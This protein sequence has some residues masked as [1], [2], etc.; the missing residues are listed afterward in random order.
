MASTMIA[1]SRA[2]FGPEDEQA[3]IDCLRSGMVARGAR[4][5]AF[6]AALATRVGAA[7]GVAVP[8]G[9][10]AIELGLRVLGVGSGDEVI[11][12]TYVCRAVFE[13]VMSVGAAPVL[14]DNGAR[15]HRCLDASS[16]EAVLSS[17][18]RA[19]IA[20][21]TLGHPA[22]IAALERLGLPVIEDACQGLGGRISHDEAQFQAQGNVALGA[23]GTLGVVSF[24]GTKVL[25]LGEGGMLLSRDPALVA[26]ARDILDGEGASLGCRSGAQFSDVTAS[27]GL[28][29][30]AR[31]DAA[32]ARRAVLAA[33]YRV[34][35][36]G[37]PHLELPEPEVVPYRFALRIGA[38]RG[39]TFERLQTA[40]AERGVAV[41]RGVDA[42]NH[43]LFGARH[44]SAVRAGHTFAQ[45]E[46]DFAETLSLPIYESL[47]DEEQTQVGEALAATLD[48]PHSFG[49]LAATPSRRI[50]A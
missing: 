35:L 46:R 12:P 24:H 39:E 49:A 14:A 19:I 10:A 41:R 37:A 42:M 11:L 30:L 29:R 18:T 28:S 2:V 45:A 22:P 50:G 7:G 1:H 32:L 21:D 23:R 31:L 9:T 38:A 5:R 16:V 48:L 33:R 34:W 25:P 36:A 15:A 4:T 27:L 17:K 8:S 6:E 44:P 40:F 13:A 26:R 3:V 20:V 43:R 47:S